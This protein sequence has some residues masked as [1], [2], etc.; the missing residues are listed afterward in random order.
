MN[1]TETGAT[2]DG[3]RPSQ[4]AIPQVL[5]LVLAVLGAGFAWFA[6]IDAPITDGAMRLI[7]GAA[8]DGGNGDAESESHRRRSVRADRHD[9]ARLAAIA[10]S[11][12]STSASDMS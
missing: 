1:Q 9:Q 2:A 11:S 5:R 7:A 4:L 8:L 3:R 10:A 6:Y 12:A